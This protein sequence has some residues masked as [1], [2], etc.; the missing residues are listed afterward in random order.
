MKRAAFEAHARS[1]DGKTQNV[2]VGAS[3]ARCPTRVKRLRPALQNHF[4]SSRP[5]LFAQVAATNKTYTWAFRD[6][7]LITKGDFP[8]VLG[9]KGGPDA[10]ERE[11]RKV[12][13][14]LTGLIERKGVKG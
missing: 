9:S 13:K 8:E 7:N 11:Q 6:P 3:N 14:S 2:T 4:D 5:N 10:S 1:L 12:V